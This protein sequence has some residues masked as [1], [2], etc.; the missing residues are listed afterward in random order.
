MTTPT[1]TDA[2]LRSSAIEYLSRRDHSVRELQ[3]KL[4]Q[5]GGTLTQVHAVIAWC[6]QQNF[7]N[8]QR[9]CELLVRSK[10]NKGYGPAW[11]SQAAR[12]HGITQELIR[13]ALQDESFDWFANALTQYQKKF[14]D[15]PIGDYHDKQKRMAYLLRRGFSSEHIREALQHQDS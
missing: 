14:G 9:F 13:D 5:K 6:Q 7:Q 11:I 1:P 3:D 12:Q 10:A 8:E 2:E 4:L 15:K